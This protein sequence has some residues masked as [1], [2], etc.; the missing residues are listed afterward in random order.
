M[1]SLPAIRSDWTFSIDGVTGLATLS[2]QEL[3]PGWRVKSVRLDGADIT[4]DAT[5][6]GEGQHRHVEIVLTDEVVAVSS[7]FGSDTDDRGRVVSD[8]TVVVFP[9]NRDR[10][11]PPSPF[12]KGAAGLAARGERGRS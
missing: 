6:F 10:L 5:D 3:P 2:L 9:E 11:R 12:V 7:V 1:S 4:Y 8:Y